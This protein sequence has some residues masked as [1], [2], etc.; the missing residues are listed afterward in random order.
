MVPRTRGGDLGRRSG[1]SQQKLS[2]TQGQ[3]IQHLLIPGEL[4]VRKHVTRVKHS[5]ILNKQHKIRVLP[6][7][8]AT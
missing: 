6:F 4:A 5:L 1:E 2:Q 7:K 3:K 8:G